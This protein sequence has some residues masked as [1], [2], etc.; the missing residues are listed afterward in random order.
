MGVGTWQL[1]VEA[2]SIIKHDFFVDD[3]PRGMSI[4]PDNFHDPYG[5]H[6]IGHLSKSDEQHYGLR[7]TNKPI[8]RD[9]VG[10]NVFTILDGMLSIH[11]EIRDSETLESLNEPENVDE[12]VMIVTLYRV[13]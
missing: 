11:N 9:L 6:I 10:V 12:W 8:P 7:M 4:V 2:R 3:P 5:Y 1:T 13:D